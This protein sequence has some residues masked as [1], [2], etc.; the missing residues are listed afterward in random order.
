LGIVDP[1][2]N[3]LPQAFDQL[4]FVDESR[5][6]PI[7]HQGGIDAGSRKRGPV[8][9]EP[10]FRGGKLSSQRRLAGGFCPCDQK[11]TVRRQPRRDRR[12]GNSRQKSWQIETCTK[13]YEGIVLAAIA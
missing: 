1:S 6:R 5:R 7:E 3:G 12:L 2:T 11:A 9:V 8:L 13:I 10:H 4:A